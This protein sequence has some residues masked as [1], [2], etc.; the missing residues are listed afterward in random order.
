MS[1]DLNGIAHIQ[2][3]VF[4][5]ELSPRERI[6]LIAALTPVI[7]HDEDGDGLDDGCD[8]CPTVI[9]LSVDADGDSLDDACDPDPQVPNQIAFYTGFATSQELT[10]HFVS[11]AVTWTV[12]AHAPTARAVSACS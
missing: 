12:T 5:C 9:D 4:R 11:S 10:Q 8:T 6:E 3:S 1:V 2:L 7:N